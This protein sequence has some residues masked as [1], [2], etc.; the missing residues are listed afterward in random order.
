[1][2]HPDVDDAAV[3]G[4]PDLEWGEQV[5]AVVVLRSTNGGE[6][7]GQELIDYCHQRLASFKRPESVVFVPELPRNIMGKVL[8]RDLR[9]QFGNPA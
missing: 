9:E 6:L 4:V 5:R 3:I 2:S 1:M 8:K 7:T